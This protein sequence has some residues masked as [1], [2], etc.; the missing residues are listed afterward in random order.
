LNNK[1]SLPVT[2]IISHKV[3]RG[4]E[5]NF[6]EWSKK[7]TAKASEHDGFQSVT[8]IKPTDPSNLEYVA[9]VQWSN[10]ENLKKWQQSDDL[11]QMLKE[12]EEFSMST[13]NLHEEA[14]ME[15]WFDWP[16]DTNRMSKPAFY[17]QT[18]IAIMVVLPLIFSVGAILRP[19]LS[20]LDLPFE[21]EIVITVLI[22]APLITLIMPR[23]TKLLYPWLYPSKEN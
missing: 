20:G 12:S 5:K 4:N 8:I 22:I 9:I 3:K 7:I 21:I 10:Y 19:L 2:S 15:I 14:G 23:I 11:K 17:K 6:E 1:N 13:K 16:S 18:L